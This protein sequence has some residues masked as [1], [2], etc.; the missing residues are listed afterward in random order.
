MKRLYLF[1][2]VIL[3]FFS[4]TTV[5]KLKPTALKL[6]SIDGVS[7]QEVSTKDCV[8]AAGYISNDTEQMKIMV[9]V[10]NKTKQ[11]FDVQPI[12]FELSAD[13]KVIPGGTLQALEPDALFTQLTN[14]AENLETRAKKN[15][16]DGVHV[17]TETGVG[18]PEDAELS[19]LKKEHE[20]NKRENAEN[21]VKASKKRE[22]RAA[23]EGSLMK[24]MT[25]KSGAFATGTLLFP[26]QFKDEGKLELN[27]K[28]PSCA[29]SMVF[30]LTN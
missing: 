8:L 26:S 7:L 10:T 24:K 22:K 28:H 29:L 9:R 30:Q 23:L 2:L 17:L 11:S 12:H 6:S 21:L 4:C 19:R 20:K 18:Q 14:E 1:S 13:K 25:V 5:Y 3:P 15:N 16:W 27:M